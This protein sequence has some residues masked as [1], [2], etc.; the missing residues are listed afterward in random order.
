MLK[1]KRQQPMNLGSVVAVSLEMAL[2]HGFNGAALDI[3]SR[4]SAWIEKDLLDVG[5]ERVS[6]PDAEVTEFMSAQKKPFQMKP[7]Q[8]MIDACQPLRHSIVVCVFCLEGKF[9]QAARDRR[10]PTVRATQTAVRRNL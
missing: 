8:S 6:V 10:T 1:F 2:H 4:K 3:G 9:K 5:S 7:R